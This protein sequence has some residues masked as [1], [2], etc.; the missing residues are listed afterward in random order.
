[1]E[2]RRTERV[3]KPIGVKSGFIG[4]RRGKAVDYGFD[5]MGTAKAL[6]AH[7]AERQK[8]LAGNVAN[9]DTPAYR[10]VDMQI[11]DRLVASRPADTGTPMSATRP[12]HMVGSGW[13][14]SGMV[15]DV[16]RE[17]SPNGNTVSLED[18]MLRQADIRRE[19]NLA[20]SVY[21]AGLR[22]SRTALGR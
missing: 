7:A 17:A 5:M 10:A 11:F 19:H 12:R 16:G 15:E 3:S 13:Q 14:V 4:C 22:I 1:M 18:E 8:L 2:N 9:A 6:M 20:L 21:D